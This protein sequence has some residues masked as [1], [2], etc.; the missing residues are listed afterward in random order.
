MKESM[1]MSVLTHLE[2]HL[3]AISLMT[4]KKLSLRT[5]ELKMQQVSVM[6]LWR[7]I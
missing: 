3:K 4:L 2:F 7:F 5:L 6:V 1:L